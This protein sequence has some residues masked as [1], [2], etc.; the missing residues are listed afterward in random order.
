M[1]ENSYVEKNIYS[2]FSSDM[3]QLH[4]YRNFIEDIEELL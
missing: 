2:Y 3:R 1:Q 4:S